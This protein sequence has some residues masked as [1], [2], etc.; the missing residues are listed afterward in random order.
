MKLEEAGK[1]VKVKENKLHKQANAGV[2]DS[3][4]SQRTK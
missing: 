3:N 4:F 1:R 2:L